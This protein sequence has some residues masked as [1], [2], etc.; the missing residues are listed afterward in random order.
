MVFRNWKVSQEG[1]PSHAVITIM[2]VGRHMPFITPKEMN[3]VPCNVWANCVAGEKGIQ[4]PW[5]RTPSK[6]DR[7]LSMFGNDLLGK[8]DDLLSRDSNKFLEISKQPYFLGSIPEQ[9]R[10][11][12]F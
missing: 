3:V 7:H 10:F 1:L 9:G 4:F 5:S 12:R 8:G 2:M 6:S 11:S